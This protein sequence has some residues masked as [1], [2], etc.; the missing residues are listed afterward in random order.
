[1]QG[2]RSEVPWSNNAVA[3][4]HSRIRT[5][6]WSAFVTMLLAMFRMLSSM[7]SANAVMM[8]S[9]CARLSPSRSSRCTK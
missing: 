9:A 6:S 4:E 3:Q 2:I 1:M 8:P 7:T 5:F